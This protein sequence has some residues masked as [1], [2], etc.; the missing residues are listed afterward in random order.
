MC[1]AVV[2]TIADAIQKDFEAASIDFRVDIPS[3]ALLIGG[4]AVCIEQI[5][6]KILSNALKFT[7]KSGRVIVQARQH[8]DNVRPE[9]KDPGCGLAPHAL[10][11][12][13]E[14]FHQVQGAARTR[15]RYR[16]LACQ[17]VGPV[18]LVAAPKRFRRRRKR[19]SL[20][21]FLAPA[22]VMRS[23]AGDLLP[24]V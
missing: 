17:T 11:S 10:A 2:R 21:R 6:W 14:M 4:H 15:P 24:D 20:C 12:V 1:V 5:V 22:S 3:T 8:D 13:F 16:A 19:R 18:T 7:P 23:A 9:V